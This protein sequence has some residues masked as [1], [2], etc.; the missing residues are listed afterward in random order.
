MLSV[1]KIA[2]DQQVTSRWSGGSTTQLAICPSGADYGERNFLWRLS[3]A[4]VEQETSIFTPLPDYDRIISVVSGGL[5]LKHQSLPP[6]VLAPYGRHDFDGGI[7]TVS[8]G[9]AT[10]FNIMTLKGRCRASLETLR[11]QSGSCCILSGYSRMGGFE[12]YTKAIYCAKGAVEVTVSSG[13][14]VLEQGE[15]LLL[16]AR[17]EEDFF[18]EISAK[19]DTGLFLCDILEK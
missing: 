9:K 3:S 5:C 13:I 15:L 16:S 1:Q 8:T 19:Q 11:L 17:Q 12:R 7:Q 14:F 6:V 4:T 10:D 18:L 2:R